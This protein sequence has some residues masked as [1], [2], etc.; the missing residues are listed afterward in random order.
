MDESKNRLDEERDYCGYYDCWCAD[1]DN[2]LSETELGSPECSFFCRRCEYLESRK[3]ED[4]YY[5]E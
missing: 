5:T 1:V 4:T 3:I 2:N